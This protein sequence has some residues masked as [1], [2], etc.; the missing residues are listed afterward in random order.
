MT[1]KISAHD[2]YNY[3]RILTVNQRDLCTLEELNPGL[4]VAFS[5]G[6]FVGQKSMRRFSK[7]ALDQMNEQLIDLLKN[8]GSLGTDLL[9][10]DPTTLRRQMVV[11][12]MVTQLLGSYRE[13]PVTNDKHHEQYVKFQQNMK[14]STIL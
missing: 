9:T 10:G 4:F 7:I 13:P 12:N 14:V 5:E 1:E 6:Q 2:H 8:S 3:Q 11:D